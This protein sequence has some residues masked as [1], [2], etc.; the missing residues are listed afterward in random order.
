MIILYAKCKYEVCAGIQVAPIPRTWERQANTEKKLD[1]TWKWAKLLT[2]ILFTDVILTC[3]V[4]IERQ[5]TSR[6]Y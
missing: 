4:S 5:I 3:E 2:I 1:S 6:G